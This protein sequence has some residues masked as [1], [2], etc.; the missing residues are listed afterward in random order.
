[1]L[2]TKLPYSDIPSPSALKCVEDLLEPNISEQ[3]FCKAVRAWSVDL[4]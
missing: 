3:Q 1:M 4:Y 2:C